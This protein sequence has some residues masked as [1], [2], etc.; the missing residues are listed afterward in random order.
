MKTFK[1][2]WKLLVCFVMTF[3]LVACSGTT[4]S[5]SSADMSA[6]PE[7]S[8]VVYF[9]G[10]GNTKSVAEKVADL[11]DSALFEIVPE[12]PYT[13]DD[14]NFNDENSRV[15]SEYENEEPR[16][17]SLQQAVP[18]NWDQYDT[19]YLGYPIW[20]GMPAWPMDTFVKGVNW[21]GKTIDP[22]CTTFSSGVGNSVEQL[23]SEADG[24]D[25]KE[26]IRFQEHPDDEA[27]R[28]WLDSLS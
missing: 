10:T 14:L 5:S 15:V 17:M 27:I 3:A 11:T 2:G 26:G 6:D 16:T 24:G 28:S 8:I 12:K 20:W 9:S 25:W 18:D 21:N 22:F 7:K 19:V 13:S 23:K 4:E 1:K